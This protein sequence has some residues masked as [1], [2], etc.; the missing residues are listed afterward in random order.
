MSTAPRTQGPQRPRVLVVMPVWNA[1]A[2]LRDA[3]DSVLA[4]QGVDFHVL[5]VDDG[6]T[7][8]SPA[9]LASYSDP[10]LAVH[11]IGRRGLCA[12]MNH[13]IHYAAEH[14]YEYLMRMDSDDVS[15]PGRFALLVRYLDAWPECAA[16]SSN[17]EYF[18]PE[19]RKAGTSTVSRRPRQIA[20]E[21]RHGLRGLIQGACCFRT[22]AL[23]AIEGYREQFVAAEDADL[24][25]RLVERFEVGNL[26]EYLYRIRTSPSS[27]SRG[28]LH[29]NVFF[30]RYALDCARRRRRHQRERSVE[31]YLTWATRYSLGLRFEYWAMT[32][33]EQSHRGGWRRALVAPAALMSPWRTALRA[34]RALQR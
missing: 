17:C 2:T 32:L 1:A 20:F 5:V 9:I 12:A 30:S 19:G 27:R 15:K 18:T 25:L 33:W 34:V 7:D 13:A 28:D 3:L 11:S 22:S 4:Q 29:R 21:I 14:G 16:A 10:R 31:E 26:R 24:F 23:M 8:G 6:S